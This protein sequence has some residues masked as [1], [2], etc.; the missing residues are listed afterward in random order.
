[1]IISII[2]IALVASLALFGVLFLR[3]TPAGP[4]LKISHSPIA[5][6]TIGT[7]I[8]VGANVT[9]PVRNVTLQYAAQGAASL[10]R[11]EMN[12]Q[13]PSQYYYVVPGEQVTG[14]I[15]YFITAVDTSGNPIQTDTYHITVSD[16]VF[17]ASSMALTVYETKSASAQVA[18]LSINGFNQQIALSASGAPQGLAVSF[19][20]NLVASGTTVQ[21]NVA[22]DSTAPNGTFSIPLTATYTPAGASP[23]TRQATAMITVAD[24]DLQVSPSSGQV[25]RGATI[26]YTL[27]LTIQRGFVDPV[28][29]KVAN[30]PQGATYQLIMNGSTI[31]GG[32]PG[33]IAITLQITT[34]SATKSGTY[35]LAI[36]ATGGGIIHSQNIQLTVR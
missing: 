5:T 28:T 30:L 2:L 18:L 25:S 19:T 4:A 17:Q 20:P 3:S 14:N 27:T 24:F 34:T 26:S 35:T 22:A 13:E 23:V 32:G 15:A 29:V 33:T 36:N 12:S 1:L 16:F 31:L 10:K 6:A 11:V 8:E 9:G 21:M 7:P